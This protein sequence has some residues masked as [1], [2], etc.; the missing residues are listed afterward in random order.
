MKNIVIAGS[1]SLQ[2]GYDKWINYWEKEKGGRVID[3][4][5]HIN[6]EH[7]IEKYPE[8]HI[9][10]IRN[11]TEADILFIANEDKNG[12]EGYIGAETFAELAFGVAQ[13]FV[14]KKDLKVI[15]AKKPSN[16]IQSSE[17]IS[18]WLE[19]GWIEILNQ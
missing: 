8:V 18:L 13:K 5:R 19:L 1:V 4:P 3:Y 14:Y 7:F 2:E 15:L 12:V 11:I 9:N 10:F 6:P 17:E 16:K